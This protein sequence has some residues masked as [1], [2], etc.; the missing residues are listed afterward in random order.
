MQLFQVAS[1][2]VGTGCLILPGEIERLEQFHLHSALR[3][4]WEFTG[5]EGTEGHSGQGEDSRSTGERDAG[6]SGLWVLLGTRSVNRLGNGSSP[7]VCSL[8]GVFTCVIFID[9]GSLRLRP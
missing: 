3:R 6:C 2:E 4:E 9:L 5:R 8:C 7:F 1:I